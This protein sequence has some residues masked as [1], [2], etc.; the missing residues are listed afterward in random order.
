[1]RTLLTYR[2]VRTHLWGE[3]HLDTL[4]CHTP[5]A[6]VLALRTGRELGLPVQLKVR[7]IE[8]LACPGLPTIVGQGRSDQANPIFLVTADQQVGIHIARIDELVLREQALLGQ[9]LLNV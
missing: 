1:M 8:A 9:P 6:A 7:C 2:A 3:D 4:P 5:A